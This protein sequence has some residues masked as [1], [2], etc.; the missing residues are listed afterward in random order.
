MK[1][2][3][4]KKTIINCVVLILFVLV[5]NVSA[6]IR[7]FDDFEY[8]VDRSTNGS[9]SVFMTQGPWTDVKTT[10]DGRNA[11]GY[12]YTTQ[13][14]TGNYPASPNTGLDWLVVFKNFSYFPFQETASGGNSY[15]TLE[16]FHADNQAVAD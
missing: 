2:L 14:I 7:L 16:A 10:Q 12:L 1:Y 9:G 11:C 8:T 5:N 15:Y 4:I 13:S 6:E 3:A